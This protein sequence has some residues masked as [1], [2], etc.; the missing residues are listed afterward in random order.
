MQTSYMPL[1]RCHG[2][3][4]MLRLDQDHHAIG[5]ALHRPQLPVNPARASISSWKRSPAHLHWIGI[6][7][8]DRAMRGEGSPAPSGGRVG[9]IARLLAGPE[10]HRVPLPAW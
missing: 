7:A 10:H 6:E 3:G 4:T 5:R 1:C 9:V 8:V 2:I